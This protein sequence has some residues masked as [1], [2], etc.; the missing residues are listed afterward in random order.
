MNI[1]GDRSPSS[2]NPYFLKLFVEVVFRYDLNLMDGF[3]ESVFRGEIMCSL[4][5]PKVIIY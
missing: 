4:Y 1:L 5:A 2:V 3:G